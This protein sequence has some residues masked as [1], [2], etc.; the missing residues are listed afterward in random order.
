[1][2]FSFSVSDINVKF[3]SSYQ[4]KALCIDRGIEPEDVESV[5]GNNDGTEPSPAKKRKPYTPQI[6]LHQVTFDELETQAVVIKNYFNEVRERSRTIEKIFPVILKSIENLMNENKNLSG[7]VNILKLFVESQIE[8]II[9]N[10][11]DICE[12]QFE[13]SEMSKICMELL[14][15]HFDDFINY[16]FSDNKK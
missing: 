6:V 9:N 8:K 11:T 3:T 12:E 7:S 14:T 15:F 16:F 5:N 4:H 13:A 10:V 1:M 2:A